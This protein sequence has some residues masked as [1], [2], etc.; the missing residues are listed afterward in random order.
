[1]TVH[2]KNSFLPPKYAILSL[3]SVAERVP[4]E[5]PVDGLCVP[6]ISDIADILLFRDIHLSHRQPFEQRGA[7]LLTKQVIKD[8]RPWTI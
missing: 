6:V 1:M 4:N 8:L 2:A 7:A 5:Y 3:L